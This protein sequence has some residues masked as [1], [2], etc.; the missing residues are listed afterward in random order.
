MVRDLRSLVSGLAARIWPPSRSEAAATESSRQVN[1]Q[2]VL[3]LATASLIT[4]TFGAY[5]EGLGLLLA[6]MD[7]KLPCPAED[8]DPPC[9]SRS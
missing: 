4:G 6:T 3:S 5:A 1:L 2:G 9:R 8:S 7:P